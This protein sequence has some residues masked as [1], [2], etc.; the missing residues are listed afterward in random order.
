MHEDLLLELRIAV[1]QAILMPNA[2]HAANSTRWVD[3]PLRWANESVEKRQNLAA[4]GN[5]LPT[6]LSL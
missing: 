2:L 4:C 6:W 5:A 3:V 1:Q